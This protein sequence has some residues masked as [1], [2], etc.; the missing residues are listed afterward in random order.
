MATI[1]YREGRPK[2]WLAQI[3]RKGHPVYSKAFRLKDTAERW[4]RSEEDRIEAGGLLDFKKY[5][6]TTAAMLAER[7]LAE[8]SPKKPTFET[9]KYVIGSFLKRSMARKSLQQISTQDGASYRDERL[10]ETYREGKQIKPST[11][12]REINILQ[13]IFK[14]AKTEWGYSDI[15]NPFEDLVIKGSDIPRVRRVSDEELQR[16]ETAVREKCRG[17]NKHYAQLAIYLAIQTG[18]RLQ[19]IFNL[20]FQDVDMRKR[21]I[22]IYKSKMDYKNKTP[23]R[24][25]VMPIPA[26]VIFTAVLGEHYFPIPTEKY[27]TTIFP[28]TKKA[29]K[30]TWETVKRIAGVAD[31][32][33]HDLRHEAGSRFDEL[34]LTKGEHDL[35]MGHKNRDIGTR[36]THTDEKKL[37]SIQQKLDDPIYK[38]FKTQE[39]RD[40]LERFLNA[41]EMAKRGDPLSPI[42]L[43]GQQMYLLIKSYRIYT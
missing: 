39:E 15:R 27:R 34:E 41:E 4:A 13:H 17:A 38:A 20:R 8:I 16:L 33:F 40:N 5:Q 32:T 6:S 28:M 14:V 37:R 24:T 29:F 9:E 11:V 18:M 7:Y 19:E 12:R 30:Q 2:P 26:A 21:R 22:T 1:V 36:Y 43:T 23:G 42:T 10:N 3:K 25:I 31:L 35:M